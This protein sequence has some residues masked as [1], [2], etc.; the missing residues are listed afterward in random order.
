MSS[1]IAHN[2][3]LYLQNVLETFFPV[4]CLVKLL[5]FELQLS[6]SIR[7]ISVC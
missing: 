6:E 3:Y 5:L 7:N 1:P 4:P 2:L